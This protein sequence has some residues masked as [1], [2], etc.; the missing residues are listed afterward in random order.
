M[1]WL[2]CREW[3]RYRHVIEMIRVRKIKGLDIFSGFNIRL[4]IFLRPLAASGMISQLLTN[5]FET[6]EGRYY[7]D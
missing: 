5:Q 6:L 3:W 4:Y 7:L 2:C 1:L